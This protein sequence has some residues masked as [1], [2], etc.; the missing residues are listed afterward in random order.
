VV[1]VSSVA[2][3]GAPGIDFE[4]LRQPTVSRTGV[5]GYRVS[6]LA[7][8]LFSAELGRRLAGTGVTTYS[9]HP[10]VIATDIWRRIPWPARPLFTAFMKSADEGARTTL[11][12][13]TAAA[14]A[15]ESGLY[16][17]DDGVPRTPSVPAQDAALA[18]ELWRRSE[19]WTG[20]NAQP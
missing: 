1:T 19:L 4:T 14:L 18:S 11:N 20:A 13:A 9:L 16:Y 8:V 12:C 7:N 2:H 5:P 6:K 15:S 3:C 17:D 10:G